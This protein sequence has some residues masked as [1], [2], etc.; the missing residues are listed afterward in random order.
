MLIEKHP[1]LADKCTVTKYIIASE[2]LVDCGITPGLTDVGSVLQVSS[3]TYEEIDAGAKLTFDSSKLPFDQKGHISVIKDSS[4]T[5]A[6][7]DERISLFLLYKPIYQVEDSDFGFFEKKNVDSVKKAVQIENPEGIITGK[8]IVKQYYRDGLRGFMFEP[9]DSMRGKLRITVPWAKTQQMS[10]SLLFHFYIPEPHKLEDSVTYDY[11]II[12]GRPTWTNQAFYHLVHYLQIKRESANS[13]IVIKF[14]P[15]ITQAR[16][17]LQETNPSRRILRTLGSN[18]LSIDLP[19]TGSQNYIH[20]AMTLSGSLTRIVTTSHFFTTSLSLVVW[21]EGV[22]RQATGPGDISTRPMETIYTAT[23]ANS[24][25]VIEITQ[26][27]FL[28]PAQNSQERRILAAPNK[29]PAGI[30]LMDFKFAYG[31]YPATAIAN[32][33]DGMLD[34]RCIIYGFSETG[35]CLLYAFLTSSSDS[36]DKSI[37]NSKYVDKRHENCPPSRCRYCYKGQKCMFNLPGNNEDLYYADIDFVKYQY[38]TSEYA[39]ITASLFVAV[40]ISPTENIHVRCPLNCKPQ[41]L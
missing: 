7:I 9:D 18:L 34:N 36:N 32:P 19:F 40:E 25:L 14:N 3:G 6:S 35:S 22:R 13:K 28:P 37:K 1:T 11:K 4:F 8:E 39:P 33:P 2:G 16:R 20:I 29:N 38:P 41:N 26:R 15:E 17:A 10:K 12:S 23:E 21:H 30:R 27:T 31:G 5:A 24:D